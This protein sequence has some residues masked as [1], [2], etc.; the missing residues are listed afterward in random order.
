VSAAGA[1]FAS[2]TQLIWTM[3]TV[4]QV[5]TPS[6]TDSGTL[7]FSIPANLL[8]TAGNAQILAFNADASNPQRVAPVTGNGCPVAFP[9]PIVAPA[10]PS[11][12]GVNP[13]SE[14]AVRPTPLDITVSG[15]NFDSTSRITV[16]GASM[17]TT[18]VS[19]TQLKTSLTPAQ[20]A[21]VATLTI[22]VSGA[23]G[24]AAFRVLPVPVPTLTITASPANLTSVQD[25]TLQLNQTNP[26]SRALRMTLS[27]SFAPNADNIPAAGLPAAAQPVFGG[28][29][30]TLQV[31]I[32]TTGTTVTLPSTAL[33]KPGTVAGTVTIRVAA[34][35]AVGSTD[36]LLPSPAPQ[37]TVVLARS[38]PV[39]D[40]AVFAPVTGGFNL[41]VTATSTPRNLTNAVEQ[42]NLAAGKNVT[43]TTSFTVDLQSLG[44]AWFGSADGLSFG[45][46]FKL[47]IPF[48]VTDITVIDSATVT[49]C[50]TSGASA[51][52]TA[53]R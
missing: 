4:R 36:S 8:A 6:I 10:V 48:T 27:L 52:A 50:N 24:T 12:T 18:F 17:D 15:T 22:A 35:V 9:I 34:L 42:F 13:S 30:Q 3:G 25:V 53:R 49:L 1:N 29:G 46:Q 5:L 21:K 32:P 33:V 44:T 39:I 19:A 40:T 43:G 37:V 28:G 7:T 51:T 26:S 16:D 45:G 2:F 41:E 11:V 14:V 23:T 31:D 47:R 38:A 20:L